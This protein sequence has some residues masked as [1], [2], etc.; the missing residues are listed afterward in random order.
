MGTSMEARPSQAVDGA[1]GERARQRRAAAEA[2]RPLGRLAR[3]PGQ[4]PAHATATPVPGPSPIP[5]C[6]PI[7]APSTPDPGVPRLDARRPFCQAT[8]GVPSLEVTPPSAP[9]A[10]QRLPAR[11]AR[12]AASRCLARL[13]GL[14]AHPAPVRPPPRARQA[15][16]RPPPRP[17][18]RTVGRLDCPLQ[19]PCQEPRHP[20]PH[21]LAGASAR[22]VDVASVR[23]APAPG[24]PTRQLLV[25]TVPPQ[26]CSHGR[27]GPPWRCPFH[28]RLQARVRPRPGLAVAVDARHHPSVRDPLLDHAPPLVVVDPVAA[29]LDV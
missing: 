11:S 7:A 9:D 24:P 22:A 15:Q 14:L 3:V 21:P 10:Y 19:A 6:P 26:S 18:H 8:G 1:P 29:L 27:H 12:P 17:V 25:Q 16:Q 2:P 28:R 4:V 23:I 5:W 20:G 13:Q